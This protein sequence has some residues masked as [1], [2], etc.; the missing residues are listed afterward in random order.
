MLFN[1]LVALFIIYVLIRFSPA[2][3]GII[4]WFVKLVFGIKKSVDATRRATALAESTT[5]HAHKA[6]DTYGSIGKQ[7]TAAL[8]EHNTDD[9]DNTEKASPASTPTTCC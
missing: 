5:A 3:V 6:A 2:V 4:I 8:A 7:I 9:D 1:G